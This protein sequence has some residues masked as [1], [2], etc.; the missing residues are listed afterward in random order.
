ME[1]RRKTSEL[2]NDAILHLRNLGIKKFIDSNADASQLKVASIAKWDCADLTELLDLCHQEISRIRL[3][4]Y[5]TQIDQHTLE[6]FQR[7]TQSLC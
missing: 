4:N 3:K 6:Y 7:L 5:M 1:D 2:L